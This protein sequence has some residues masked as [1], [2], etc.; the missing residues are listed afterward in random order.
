MR[1]AWIFAASIGAGLALAPIERGLAAGP[2]TFDGIWTVEVDCASVGDV[3]GY[4]W[5]FPAEVSSGFMSGLYRSATSSA[6]GHITG[7]IHPDGSAL[8]TMVG[9]TGPEQR[10]FGHQKPGVPFHYTVDAQFDGPS[11]SGKRNEQ[12]PCALTF[13]K[14]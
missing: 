2:G 9:R 6:I 3:E 13:G 8:L 11:G 14:T 10:S 4:D 7:H 5:S 1:K 12:R